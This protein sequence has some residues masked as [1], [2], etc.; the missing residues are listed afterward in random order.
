MKRTRVREVPPRVQQI[1][2]SGISSHLLRGCEE[3][4]AHFA[5][6]PILPWE[7]AFY[8]PLKSY[9]AMIRRW[10]AML[11]DPSLTEHE[12]CRFISNRPY[13]LLVRSNLTFFVLSELRL[14]ADYTVDFVVPTEN[15]SMGMTYEFIELESPH[16]APFTKNGDPSARFSHA[17]RQITDW[18]RWLRR[19]HGE[20]KRLLPCSSTHTPFSFTIVIGT[21]E[22]SAAWLEQRNSFSQEHNVVTRSF[23]YLTD[24]MCSPVIS[25]TN[26]LTGS[27]EERGVPL[28]LANALRN[29]FY[30]T[31]SDKTWRAIRRELRYHPHFI[32]ANADTLLKHRTY[33]TTLYSAFSEHC[34][35]HPR[36]VK[37][38]LAPV[39]RRYTRSTE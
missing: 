35:R 2:R 12:Y 24:N 4:K 25:H 31:Y 6:H 9:R 1:P 13:F 28:E 33:D 36:I 7:L 18:R 38:Y 8:T 14:G 11:A 30:R 21:R 32:W 3:L 26:R 37:K 22:N 27:S 29:P 17:L 34:R 20:A 10:K 5:G 15:H 19:N 16:V 39:M 23:D